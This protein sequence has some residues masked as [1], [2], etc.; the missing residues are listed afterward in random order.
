MSLNSR[1]GARGLVAMSEEIPKVKFVPKLGRPRKDKID[2]WPTSMNITF[3]K[4]WNESGR[5]GVERDEEVYRAMLDR[6]ILKPGTDQREAKIDE[7]TLDI[8]I[9]R[10]KIQR[11]TEDV[12]EY[13]ITVGDRCEECGGR[14]SI[15]DGKEVMLL[16]DG[17]RLDSSGNY[18]VCGKGYHVECAGL[19]SSPDGEFICPS[20]DASR[21]LKLA[22]EAGNQEHTESGIIGSTAY[23]THL[24]SIPMVPIAAVR[25]GNAPAAMER[26]VTS[27]EAENTQIA[28]IAREIAV[29]KDLKK[30]SLEGDED[31]NRL[32]EKIG[33]KRQQIQENE[34]EV[35]KV[36]KVIMAA[37]HAIETIRS[38]P[39][40]LQGSLK[41]LLL[42]VRHYQEREAHLV[43]EARDVLRPELAGLEMEKNEK[44]DRR[45]KAKDEHD[46]LEKKLK[47][48]LD[49]FQGE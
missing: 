14:H 34:N 45:K 28:R 29:L 15:G 39:M 33:L 10:K 40:E 49:A 1:D 20:C 16:C 37:Q 32:T 7:T 21:L 13:D 11:I 44:I 36:R 12:E 30:R 42:D 48:L 18:V 43:V 3:W 19:E 27:T 22:Q 9:V 46:R 6:G 35:G 5:P 47:P 8:Q 23:E 31:N 38:F 17:R 2:G 26:T 24:E 25:H 4:V 41:Q